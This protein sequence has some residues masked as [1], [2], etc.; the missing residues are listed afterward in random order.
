MVIA[1]WMRDQGYMDEA[2]VC[3]TA[4]DV[5]W[6]AGEW[7]ALCNRDVLDDGTAV[8]FLLGDG[9]RGLRTK[10][11]RFQGVILDS[12]AL[13][14]TWRAKQQDKGGR[15]DERV[16]NFHMQ[17]F[18]KVWDYANK[19]SNLDWIGTPH[20]LRHA[21]AARDVEQNTRSLE[22]VRRRGRWRAA[23]S[24]AR[25]TKT[26]LLIQARARAP[27]DLFAQGKNLVSERGA[28]HIRE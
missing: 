16:F 4:M 11:G 28:R 10:T 3:E 17:H 18:K 9:D 13:T 15:P 23:D 22:A 14:D 24:V 7:E 27:P 19:F 26:W 2:L 5:Y 1:L 21:G 12:A 25:Y 8:A 6:R 20:A